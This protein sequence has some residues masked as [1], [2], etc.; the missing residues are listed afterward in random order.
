MR[1]PQRARIAKEK[2]AGVSPPCLAARCGSKRLG[3]RGSRAREAGKRQ[4]CESSAARG[5]HWC[6]SDSC[7]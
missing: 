1:I 2:S 4:G 5:L 6:R 7:A 3:G